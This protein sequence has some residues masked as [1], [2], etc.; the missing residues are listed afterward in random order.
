MGGVGEWLVLVPF[1]LFLLSIL[2]A[3]RKPSEA[4]HIYKGVFVALCFLPISYALHHTHWTV[5]QSL[6][7][8]SILGAFVGFADYFYTKEERA[9][10]MLAGY[11]VSCV[12]A[13]K[14]MSI[15][16]LVGVVA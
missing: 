6:V 16:K 2:F 4:K 15:A 13:F 11:Q 9:V 3:S 5:E 8:A 7:W 1:S 10:W 12:F 14:V